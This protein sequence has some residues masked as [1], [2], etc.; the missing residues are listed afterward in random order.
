[1]VAHE[2]IVL[3]DPALMMLRAPNSLM[4]KAGV[5]DI[6]ACLDLR[7]FQAYTWVPCVLIPC[8]E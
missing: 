7:H 3:Q 5:L 1:M 8:E 6:N 4:M 2:W